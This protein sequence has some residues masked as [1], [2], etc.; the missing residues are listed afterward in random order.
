MNLI[1]YIRMDNHQE[2]MIIKVRDLIQE[3][4]VNIFKYAFRN[5]IS[6]IIDH[7]SVQKILLQVMEMHT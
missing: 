6:I 4:E 2:V 5:A 1:V 3:V 7:M